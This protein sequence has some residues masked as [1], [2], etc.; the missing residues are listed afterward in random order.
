MGDVCVCVVLYRCDICA[1]QC[2][3][4]C[5]DVHVGCVCVPMCGDQR[6][7]LGVFSDCCLLLKK[8][9][10]FYPFNYVFL[11]GGEC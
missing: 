7:T 11:G 8:K 6:L 9:I 2:M 10:Y 1:H 3:H 5:V 4:V